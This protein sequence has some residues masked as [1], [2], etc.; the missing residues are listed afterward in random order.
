MCPDAIVG[1]TKEEMDINI[2]KI[3]ARTFHEL[4]LRAREREEAA[5]LDGPRQDAVAGQLPGR[6]TL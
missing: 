6:C 3:D 2:D 4:D 5:H 1:I